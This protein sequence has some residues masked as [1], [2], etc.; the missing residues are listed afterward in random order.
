MQANYKMPEYIAHRI[1]RQFNFG[2]PE[3]LISSS[4]AVTI[5]LSTAISSLR[6][7]DRN[8]QSYRIVIE[9]E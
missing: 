3:G 6:I 9:A 1:M 7:T 2:D 8:G 5:D 4:E